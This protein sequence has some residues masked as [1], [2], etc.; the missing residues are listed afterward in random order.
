MASTSAPRSRNS[1]ATSWIA[2]SDSVT[3]TTP[4]VPT[5]PARRPARSA[6]PLRFALACGLTTTPMPGTSGRGARRGE[7]PAGGLDGLPPALADG[8]VDAVVAED[9]LEAHDPLPRARHEARP[10]ERVER[11]QVHLGAEPVQQAYEAARV[12]LAVVLAAQHDVFEGDALAAREGE[13]AAGVEQDAQRVAA[14]DGHQARALHVGGGGERHGQVDARLGDQARGPRDEAHRG[15]P[16]AP[17]RGR[18]TP[19]R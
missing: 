13:R 6:P 10:R 3:R 18:G 7:L 1:R 19:L 9:R 12:G 15:D 4:S 2:G 14:V 16:D 8:R 5:I 17:G 11:D